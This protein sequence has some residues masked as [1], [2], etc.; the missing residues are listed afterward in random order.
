M[1]LIAVAKE[2][3][4]DAHEGLFDL[5][6]EPYVHHLETVVEITKRITDDEMTIAI[7]WLH[8][9]VEDTLDTFGDLIIQGYPDEVIGGVKQMTRP[10]GYSYK[11]YI[12]EMTNPRARIV[13]IAD[14]LHN[15]DDSRLPV[16]KRNADRRAKY[17]RALVE[18]VG[19]EITTK[20]LLDDYEEHKKTKESTIK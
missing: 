8:D 18:L 6:G 9:I 20:A 19:D 10:K 2:H 3:A 5:A 1:D 12:E 15:Q 13:K 11:K 4:M 16:E 7:A 17:H 14:L